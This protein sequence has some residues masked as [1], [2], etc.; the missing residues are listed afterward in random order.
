MLLRTLVLDGCA[1]REI[2][3]HD[4]RVVKD[5][6]RAARQR[7]VLAHKVKIVEV[8]SDVIPQPIA[9]AI[10]HRAVLLAVVVVR[11]VLA[12]RR[13]HHDVTC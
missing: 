3:S 2:L 9:R 13:L 4:R 12:P 8:A 6:G 10:E 11:L 5:V 1:D 7:F